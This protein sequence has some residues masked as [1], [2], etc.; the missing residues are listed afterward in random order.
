MDPDQ[1]VDQ[2]GPHLGQD[3]S[4][5]GQVVS[6]HVLGRLHLPSREEYRFTK[7]GKARRSLPEV[8]VDVIDVLHHQLGVPGVLSINVLDLVLLHALVLDLVVGDVHGLH[9]VGLLETGGILLD[10]GSS[11]LNWLLRFLEELVSGADAVV[12]RVLDLS[13]SGSLEVGGP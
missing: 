6:L 13:Q 12:T 9:L 1:P 7:Q 2:D 8:V 10:F 3:L 4:L 5:A 11:D